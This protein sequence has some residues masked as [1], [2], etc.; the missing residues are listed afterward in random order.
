MSAKAT[1]YSKMVI[2]SAL[3]LPLILSL[4]SLSSPA[5]ADLQFFQQRSNVVGAEGVWPTLSLFVTKGAGF[6]LGVLGFTPDGLFLQDLG[7]LQTSAF[8]TTPNLHTATLSPVTL[9]GIC[10]IDGPSCGSVPPGGFALVTI[11]GA[12]WSA[13]GPPEPSYS[14][15]L[16]PS[17]KGVEVI[18]SGGQTIAPATATGTLNGQNLAQSDPSLGQTD[19]FKA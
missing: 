14:T 7:N 9:L 15:Q 4:F 18:V 8:Q 6:P 2:T 17:F 11:G 12:T 13:S 1:Q 3:A 10:P 5:K 16:F 19:I